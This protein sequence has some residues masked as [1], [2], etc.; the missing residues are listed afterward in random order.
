MDI[1]E[2]HAAV[3]KNYRSFIESFMNKNEIEKIFEKLKLEVRST[4]NRHGWFVSE[5]RKILRV[6]YSRGKGSIPGR[7]SDKIRSQLKGPSRITVRN[8]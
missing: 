7:A 1:L 8:D 5:G 4:K 2:V 3:M 6:H